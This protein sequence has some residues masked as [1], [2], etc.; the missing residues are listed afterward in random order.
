MKSTFSTTTLMLAAFGLVLVAWYPRD[1]EAIPAFAR[2]YEKNCSACHLA[3][4]QL[5]SAGRQFKEAGYRFPSDDEHAQKVSDFLYWDKHFPISAVLVARPYDKKDSGDTKLRAVHEL[6]I[7]AAGVIAKQASGWFELEAE[8]ET[9]FEP[10][11][12]NATFGWHLNKA[13][14]VQLSYAPYLWSDPYGLLGDHFRMT[15]GH[16]KLIDESFG[17]ADAGGKLRSNRQMIAAYGRPTKALFYNVGYSGAAGDSEGENPSNFHGRLAFDVTR[18][19]MVGAFGVDGQDDATGLDFS[20]YGL[21]FQADIGGARIQAAYVKA[22]DDVAGGGQDKNNVYSIQGMYVI[23]DGVRPKWVPVVRLDSYE[24]NDGAS[25]YQELTVNL[26]HYFTEN[27]KGYIEYWD[28]L[29][30]PAGETED[31]RITLQVVAAF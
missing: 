17:G 22:E 23:K 30:V 18:D 12:G 21:D 11:V 31:N 13:F 1:A 28:Q 15:R 14:N 5:N 24:R 27:V 20:R 4:P 10:E 19:V 25:E 26:T 7:L 9:D 3:W 6:E 29:D 2:K 8:D 16:V